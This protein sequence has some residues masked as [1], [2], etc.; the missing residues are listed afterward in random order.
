M[1]EHVDHG[2]AGILNK[3]ATDAPWLVGERIYDAQSAAHNLSM[4]GVNCF[5]VTDVN[6][7]AR[8]RVL[9][10]SWRDEDLSCGVGRRGEAK[11]WILHRDFEPKDLDVEV[12]G[13]REVVSIGVRNDSF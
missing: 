9:H 6:P 8:W 13:G 3:E 2:A 10:P 4:H 5:R 1:G 7:Q 12:P 11:D